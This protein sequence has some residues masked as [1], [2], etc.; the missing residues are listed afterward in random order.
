MRYV[1]EGSVRRLGSVLRVNAQLIS[2]ETGGHLWADRY[3][4]DIADLGSGQERLL[5]RMR[6]ALAMNLV[7]IEAERSRRE[8]PSNP[9]AFDLILR[10]RWWSNQ[11]PSPERTQ[12]ARDFYYQASRRDPGS[13]AA[14][15]GVANTLSEQN[16]NWAGQWLSGEDLDLAERLV[17]DALTLSPSSEAALVARA[18]LLHGQSRFVDLAAPARRLVELY[19]NNPEG[20]FYLA[21]VRQFD[22]D[23]ADAV[24]MFERSIQL[25]PLEPG[26]FQR[27]AFMAFS[28]MQAGRYGDSAAWFAR[29]LAAAPDA[30]SP[31]RARSYHN[32]SASL[33]L[34][35]RLDEARRAAREARRL[36]PFDTVR[37]HYPLAL[38]SPALVAHEY[39]FRRGLALAGV[40]DH[41]EEDMDFGVPPD[42]VL[43]TDLSGRTS[44]A[45]PGATTIRTDD[46][47]R[48]LKSGV[49]PIVLDTVMHFWGRS[50]PGAVGLRNAGLGGTLED[51]IQQ[52]L[53]QVMAELTNGAL[54]K[55]IVAMGWNSERFD[56][57][58]LAL[59]LSALGYQNVFWYRGGREAWE[60]A[61]LPETDL[62]PLDW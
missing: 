40:R 43:H 44:T 38:D 24:A 56:G 51:Q 23:F 49:R 53:R 12:Q 8:R 25:D 54:D 45:V 61:G 6:G 10:A 15:T 48:V 35:G 4:Q 31:L 2:T 52:R 26:I 62:S 36:W 29:S 20:Y 17:R 27:Y 42:S 9:D 41:A 59:R 50:L 39:V 1:V 37:S 3:D 55:P 18:R 16:M 34:A 14:M 60:V 28:M 11:P 58:N 47:A 13:I 33:A 21:R 32:M 22:G 46:L 5:A 57:R 30:P 19:P 7:D